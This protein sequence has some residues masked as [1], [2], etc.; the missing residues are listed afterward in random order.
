MNA[1]EA[2]FQMLTTDAGV[3]AFVGSRVFPLV[4]PQDATRPAV[5]YQVI[6]ETPTHAQTGYSSHVI[7]RWQVTVEAETYHQAHAIKRLIE[8]AFGS[9]FPRDVGTLRVFAVLVVNST[10]GYGEIARVPVVRID[11]DM[12]HN[13]S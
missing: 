13:E 7:T 12:Q 11:I 6:S 1:A 3:A 10:D 9:G 5:A 4:V 2:L 8:R